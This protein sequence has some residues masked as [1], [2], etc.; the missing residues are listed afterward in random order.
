MASQVT[1]RTR[2]R[3]CGIISKA[4]K[5]PT[6]SR[7]DGIGDCRCR[8]GAA[9]GLDEGVR[10]KGPD[11]GRQGTAKFWMARRHRSEGPAAVKYAAA[12]LTRERLIFGKNLEQLDVRYVDIGDCPD[13]QQF[14]V[15][16][17]V[18]ALDPGG[19]SAAKGA[20]LVAQRGVLSD[21]EGPGKQLMAPVVGYRLPQQ[22]LDRA[23]GRLG[24][25]ND[26][27]G[28]MTE[29]TLTYN[30]R[31]LR[32]CYLHR[33]RERCCRSASIRPEQAGSRSQYGNSG[34]DGQ[35]AAAFV[36]AHSV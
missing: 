9:H 17:R 13:E 4:V 25:V 10:L 14:V 12:Q 6:A 29:A 2:E 19:Q 34:T 20:S 35:L 18:V 22:F 3:L 1:L 32:Q 23:A 33:G 7:R 26:G 16:P 21:A 15:Y 31:H 28:G 24:S 11:Q 5:K 36:L 30:S 27:L 8:G